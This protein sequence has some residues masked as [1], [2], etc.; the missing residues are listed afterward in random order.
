MTFQL[1][2]F[3]QLPNLFWILVAV[4]TIAFLTLLV[5]PSKRRRSK[6]YKVEYATTREEKR[7]VRQ[8]SRN[9]TPYQKRN[10]NKSNKFEQHF[11][12]FK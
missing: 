2:E 8:M 6:Q 11:R 3:G 9:S 1:F 4:G 10:K 7:W 5:A 12:R